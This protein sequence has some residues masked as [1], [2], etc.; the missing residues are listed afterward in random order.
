MRWQRHA[1]AALVAVGLI[2]AGSLYYFTRERP[3]AERPRLQ[4]KV[5]P[6]A[7]TQAGQGSQLSFV[8]D[9][10]QYRLDYGATRT[11]PDR[12]EFDNAH[13]IFKEDGTE[14]WADRVEARGVKG[15]APPAFLNMTGHVRLR[16]GE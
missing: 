1:R 5:D 11:Y 12:I 13:L 14:L 3:V 4:V 6:A 16:T 2:T 9:I 7:D 10:E 15:A 8:G